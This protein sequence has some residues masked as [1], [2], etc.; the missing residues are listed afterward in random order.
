MAEDFDFRVASLGKTTIPSP[1]TMSPTQGKNLASY[2]SDKERILFNIHVKSQDQLKPGESLEIAGPRK[3]IFFHP[4]HTK[5]G[6][7]SCGGLCPGINNVIRSIVR[8]LWYLYGVRRIIGIRNGYRGLLPEYNLEDFPLDPRVVDDIHKVG[9]TILGTS[10]GGGERTAEIVDAIERLDLNILFTIGGDGTQKGALA[11]AE[12]LERR[13]RKAAV[14]GIP[15][16]IDNDL[17]FIQRSFG[18]ETAVARAAEAV[19]SAHS[20]AHSTLNGIGLVK[21]MGRE[22]G[23]I[24]AHTALAVNEANFVLIPEV[25]FDLDGPNGLLIH[26]KRRLES[27]HHAV[28]IVAEGAGQ[29]LL[30]GTDKVDMSG[31]R[32]LADIGLHLKVA[33]QAY[34]EKIGMEINMR[35]IDPSYIIRSSTADTPDAFYCSRLGSDAVHAA[36]AGKTRLLVGLLHDCLVYVPAK[37]AVAHRKRVDPEGSLWR[38]VLIATL[39][40]SVMT[41]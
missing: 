26:L 27:A 1:I 28:I 16:T 15:K 32:V 30:Q 6:I 34:F 23:F 13:D 9:G 3:E 7:I 12:E 4:S 33:I 29:N 22:S 31:N 11:I 36:M 41:N 37:L 14:V 39:Q 38:D 24:A 10:R 40:P 19:A 20:E 8:S 18:F 5:A 25:P 2:V 35:Y 17:S 21:L